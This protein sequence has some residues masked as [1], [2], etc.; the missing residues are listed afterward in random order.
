M[1]K[2]IGLVVLVGAGFAGGYYLGQRPVGDLKSTVVQLSRNVLDTTLGAER[3]LRMRQGLVDAK[4]GLLQA[5]SE[6]LDRN[7]GDAT[8]ALSQT[9]ERLEQAAAAGPEEQRNKLGSLIKQIKEIEMELAQGKRI[10]RSRLDRIQTE[11]DTLF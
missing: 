4:S 3:N 10:P 2:L 7:Y 5:K 1:L 8:K 9:V 11:L 6:M